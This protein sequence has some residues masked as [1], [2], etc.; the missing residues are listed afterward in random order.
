MLIVKI[1]DAEALVGQ[2]GEEESKGTCEPRQA[3]KWGVGVHPQEICWYHTL[4]DWL[5]MILRMF[6][7]TEMMFF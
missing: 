3:E 2:G 6:Q 7:L 4:L 5:K 1:R